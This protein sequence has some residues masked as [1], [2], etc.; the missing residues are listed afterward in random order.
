M[1]LFD[2]VGISAVIEIWQLQR[3]IE[4]FPFKD[5]TDRVRAGEDQEPSAVSTG[6][7]LI[8]KIESDRM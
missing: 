8:S 5:K 6:L 7:I 2:Q 3:H 1:G 4:I